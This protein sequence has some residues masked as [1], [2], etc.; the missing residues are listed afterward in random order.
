MII[1]NRTALTDL[2]NVLYGPVT[3]AQKLAALK[4]PDTKLNLAAVAE[5][6]LN[7]SG[8]VVRFSLIEKP[9]ELDRLSFRYLV[10][11]NASDGEA[12]GWFAYNVVSDITFVTEESDVE[13]TVINAQRGILLYLKYIE[14][15]ILAV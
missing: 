12:H 2:L 13:S 11:K 6:G 1:P 8:E 15:D 14:Q 3:L 9:S 10:E 7:L 4:A 5:H